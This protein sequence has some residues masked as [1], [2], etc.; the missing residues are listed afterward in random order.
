MGL[1]R[2]V[3][4]I[5]PIP[6]HSWKNTFDCIEVTIN[7]FGIADDYLNAYFGFYRRAERRWKLQAN[8]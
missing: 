3:T 1:V 8:L 4:M 7:Q 5:L 6:S 2:K